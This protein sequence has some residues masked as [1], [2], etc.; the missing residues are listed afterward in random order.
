M[1]DRLGSVSDTHF[2]LFLLKKFP[3]VFLNEHFC[4]DSVLITLSAW[5]LGILSLVT[6]SI[7]L[8]F[9]GRSIVFPMSF[10]N[11]LFHVLICKPS[12]MNSS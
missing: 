12:I 2:F 6:V 9:V 10:K 7:I 4:F 8:V 3:S 11:L 1:V 5:L